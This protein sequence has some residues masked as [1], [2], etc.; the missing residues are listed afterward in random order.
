VRQFSEREGP[1]ATIEEGM[2]FKLPPGENIVKDR[3]V[4]VDEEM[5]DSC[6]PRTSPSV[7]GWF[8][9]ELRILDEIF[10]EY[11]VPYLADAGTLLG[12]VR[13]A[14]IIPW[15]DDVDVMILPNHEHLLWDPKRRLVNPKINEEFRS[16][17]LELQPVWFGLKLVP[18]ETYIPAFSRISREPHYKGGASYRWPF[19]DIYFSCFQGTGNRNIAYKAPLEQAAYPSFFHDTAD[20]WP[21]ERMKFGTMHVNGPR[22]PIPYLDRAY[23]DW[24]KYALMGMNHIEG[25][26][27]ANPVKVRLVDFCAGQAVFGE[28]ER[29]QLQIADYRITRC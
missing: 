26:I 11:E 13:H 28:V 4:E 19:T 5:N 9:H 14:G 22:N 18:M 27:N 6:F 17:G 1:Q 24:R 29:I 3:L 15:D 23:R 25:S 20:V 12:C 7:V 21:I 16:Y 2:F 10:T 8:E